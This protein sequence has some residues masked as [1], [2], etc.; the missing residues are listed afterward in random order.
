MLINAT[1]FKEIYKRE[2]AVLDTVHEPELHWYSQKH[3]IAVLDEIK[4]IITNPEAKPEPEDEKVPV[5]KPKKA[6]KKD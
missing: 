3:L 6:S 2:K 5:V 4:A 1:K